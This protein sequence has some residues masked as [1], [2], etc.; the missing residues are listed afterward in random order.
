MNV[1]A[2]TVHLT[3][4]EDVIL[5]SLLLALMLALWLSGVVPII[6]DWFRAEEPYDPDHVHDAAEL[7]GVD[8]DELRAAMEAADAEEN[9]RRWG[10]LTEENERRWKE[11]R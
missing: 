3:H 6:R 2:I 9:D 11:E 1:L 5:T 7:Y 10:V 4:L 8:T